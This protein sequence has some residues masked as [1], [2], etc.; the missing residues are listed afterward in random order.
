MEL[1]Q[2]RY[3]LAVAEE[4]HITRAAERL[5]IQQPPLSRQIK[6]I[7]Q[8]LDVQLFRR[9]ARGVELTDAGRALLEKGHKII[10]DLEHAIDATR[11]TARGE[12][13][14]IRVGVTPSGPFHP[15]LPRV[16]RSFREAFP[17]V[18][19]T[20]E[21]WPSSELIE[22][23]Q[24]E[25]MDVAFIRTSLRAP[26]SLIVTPMLKEPMVIAV[27]DG[28]ALAR[29]G[30]VEAIALR[31]LAGEMFILYSP[32]SD[33]YDATIAACRASGFSPNVGQQT[34]RIISAL[35]L[36]ATGFGISLVPASMQRMRLEG[37]AYLAIE[38]AT[39]P[40]ARLSVASRREALSAGVQKFLKL[41]KNA[42]ENVARKMP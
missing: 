26:K 12:Q 42:A 35:A 10:N 18:S 13:G 6:A 24:H 7:E 4:G 27:P 28:H 41:V 5:D 14:R 22:R 37:V 33:M 9:K 8:E 2:L 21:E 25:R 11:S 3:F 16:I 20:M 23:L 30:K 36:V 1:K 29:G 40:T 15:F 31:K 34:P 17:M 19:L 38:G 39:Q 32:G